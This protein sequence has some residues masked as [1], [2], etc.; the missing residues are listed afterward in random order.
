M[1]DYLKRNKNKFV[2]K[3]DANGTRTLFVRLSYDY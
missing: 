3:T 2:I 1:N